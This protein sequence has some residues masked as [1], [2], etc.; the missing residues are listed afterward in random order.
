MAST[1]TRIRNT[2]QWTDLIILSC[3][4]SN[5]Q[6]I[7]ESLIK[8][9]IA[10]WSQNLK[11]ES[12]LWSSLICSFML[13]IQTKSPLCVQPY[14]WE[15]TRSKPAKSDNGHESREMI[16]SCRNKRSTVPCVSHESYALCRS[17][18]CQ[19]SSLCAVRKHK[20]AKVYRELDGRYVFGVVIVPSLYA[21]D[22]GQR[23]ER[24]ST[25]NGQRKE[26][27]E[28]VRDR[29]RAGRKKWKDEEKE[30]W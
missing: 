14:G 27:T 7:S 25:E 17:W 2:T 5:F 1:S 6:L 23:I 28:R 15:H 8:Q 26:A 13:R 3:S 24:T 18:R 4:I 12:Y 20:H 11:E 10:F 19:S 21:V 16:H 29:D 30:I 22:V 9:I